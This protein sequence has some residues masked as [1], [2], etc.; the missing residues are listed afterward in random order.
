MTA[1][2]LLAGGCAATGKTSTQQQACPSGETLVCTQRMGRKESCFCESED[3][4]EQ[5]LRREKR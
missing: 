4:L 2:A 5:I 3:T 1:F